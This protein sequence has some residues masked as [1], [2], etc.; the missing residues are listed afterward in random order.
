MLITW[1]ARAELGVK[2]L[3]QFSAVAAWVCLS[4]ARELTSHVGIRRAPGRVLVT[5]DPWEY[6]LGLLVRTTLRG[7]E[8]RSQ[9][10]RAGV[11][12]PFSI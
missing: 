8:E 12:V 2:A 4:V 5:G 10:C 11:R 9:S 1:L 7:L 6:P 3:V